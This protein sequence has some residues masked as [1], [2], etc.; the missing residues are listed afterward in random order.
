MDDTID[1]AKELR[2]DRQ[3]QQML[4][5]FITDGPKGNNPAYDRGYEFNFRFTDAERS[6]VNFLMESRGMTFA[7]AFDTFIEYRRTQKES[8]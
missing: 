1:A 5:Q 3:A 2:R 6:D 8:K 4:R 7:E